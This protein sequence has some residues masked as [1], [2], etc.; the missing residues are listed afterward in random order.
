VFE[1]TS[2]S[3]ITVFFVK[4]S[5]FYTLHSSASEVFSVYL[6]VFMCYQLSKAAEQSS[7]WHYI[8]F[9]IDSVSAKTEN[10]FTSAVI[11]QHYYLACL[12][13]FSPRW[14]RLLFTLATSE[15]VM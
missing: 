15:I 14:S 12:W 2:V 1:E 11:S 3:V 9:I 5:F 4:V 13:F 7:K 8:C 10:T 6:S